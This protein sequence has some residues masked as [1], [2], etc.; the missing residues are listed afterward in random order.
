MF[1]LKEVVFLVSLS[2]GLFRTVLTGLDREQNL[3]P[4]PVSP[5]PVPPR[6]VHP[7]PV[8]QGRPT[9]G[10]RRRRVKGGYTCATTQ[11]PPHSDTAIVKVLLRLRLLIDRSFTSCLICYDGGSRGAPRP[12]GHR[13]WCPTTRVSRR[14]GPTTLG[15]QGTGSRKTIDN[16]GRLLRKDNR[17]GEDVSKE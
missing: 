6:D 9:R 2:R 7:F 10:I 5:S 16:Q 3:R 13:G 1:C 11:C 12:G 4:V 14:R 17:R 15:R 8:R